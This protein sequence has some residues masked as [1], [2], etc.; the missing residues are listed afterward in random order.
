MLYNSLVPLAILDFIIVTY[1]TSKH[2]MNPTLQ[3]FQ[4]NCFKWIE[5]NKSSL[6]LLISLSFFFLSFPFY[7]SGLTQGIWNFPSQGSNIEQVP[8]WRQVGSFTYCTTT[9]T[10]IFVLDMSFHL[11]SFSLKLEKLYL[12]FLVAQIYWQW[13]HLAFLI[14]KYLFSP[15]FLE[16]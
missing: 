10:P 5:G 14:L 3:L 8:P 9:G 1:F 13:I 2:I 4:F 7:F 12:E 15:L 6:Y 16:D 11:M